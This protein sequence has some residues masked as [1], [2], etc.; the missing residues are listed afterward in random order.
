[1]NDSPFK[2]IQDA[3]EIERKGWMPD[4]VAEKDAEINRLKKELGEAKE[5]AQDAIRC[6]SS[7]V[8]LTPN[9]TLRNM[10][11]SDFAQLMLRLK[12]LTSQ[13]Q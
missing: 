5:V 9:S 7:A 11:S 1:M 6:I 12:A 8:N 13:R 2:A 10:M 3:Q 4:P